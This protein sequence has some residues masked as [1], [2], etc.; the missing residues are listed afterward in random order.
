MVVLHNDTPYPFIV[1]KMKHLKINGKEYIA[2]PISDPYVELALSTDSR[3]YGL[4]FFSEEKKILRFNGNGLISKDEELLQKFI[5][6]KESDFV[7][8]LKIEN[9][10]EEFLK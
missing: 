1:F 6:K 4:S 10:K 9:F 5:R 7:V 3:V 8:L 2:F